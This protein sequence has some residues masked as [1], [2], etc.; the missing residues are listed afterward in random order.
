MTFLGLYDELE[1]F[2]ADDELEAFM[3]FHAIF[4]YFS[5]I[6]ASCLSHLNPNI[7]MD[8][9]S[10]AIYYARRTNLLELAVVWAMIIG[11]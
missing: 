9:K 11:R 10:P 4:Q 5:A 3:A 6:I 2:M 7:C 8:S 1:T